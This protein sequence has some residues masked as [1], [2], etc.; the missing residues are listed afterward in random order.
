MITL[1]RIFII[2]ILIMPSVKAKNLQNCKWDN[3]VGIP[4]IT[5]TKTP[6]TSAYSQQGVSKLTITK[7]DIEKS[8]AI[9]V[10]DILGMIDGIDIKQNGQRG[11]LTSLFLRGTNSNHTLVLL[12]GI[13]INDQ[14]TTQGLHNFGQDFVQT[15]QQIEVY[16]G[17]SGAHFGPSA[18]GGAINFVTAVDYQNKFSINGFNGKNNSI[19]GNYTKITDNG[20]HINFKG[21]ATNSKNGSS[22]SGGVAGLEEDGTKNHQ[23]N[24]NVEKWINNNLKFNSTAYSRRTKSHY[25]ASKSDETGYAHDKMYVIQT[26]LNKI[27]KNSEDFI[28]FHY[29]NYDREYDESGY[30]DWYDSDSFVLK[31]ER[32]IKETKK[33]SYGYGADYKYDSAEFTNNGSWSTPSA[34]GNVDN[35]GFFSNAGYR[36]SENTIFSLYARGDNHKTTGLNPTYKINLTQF[37]DKFKFSLTQ[38]TGLRNPSLYELY[39]NNGRS[40]SYKHIANPDAKPE[41]SKTN[42]LKIK[43]FFSEKLSLENTFYRSFIRES[44]L[45][46]SSFKDG[47]GYTNSKADLKQ[48]GIESS[49][50]YKNENQ[51]FTFFNTISSSKQTDGSHQLNRPDSTYGINYF[52][53]FK[54]NIIGP[55]NLNFSYKHFGKVFD[56]APAVTKVDST[57]IMNLSLSKETNFG[58]LSLNITNLLD[59]KYQR[60][61]GYEQNGR[62]LNFGFKKIY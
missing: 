19:D 44:L 48:D 43:Y 61:H 32:K 31:A 29:N 39:G 6:N 26:S 1:V 28:T 8:S 10:V 52:R 36:Y 20:F 21:S 3:R 57:D 34:K 18:I 50:I 49:F 17:P 4:C 37:I 30:F 47:T 12:N 35:L 60:P 38:S 62:Q 27:N 46:D 58:L 24:L 33:I 54:N 9:D 45:Y 55:F 2:L 59:E 7:E 41:K 11:Q 5:I 25:D 23:I 14:S 15:I 40:D 51:K 56:Y 13:P 53:K 42:E 16:K 22:R